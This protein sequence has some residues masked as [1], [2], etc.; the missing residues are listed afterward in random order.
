MRVS[1]R[2]V[3]PA[4]SPLR[5]GLKLRSTYPSHVAHDIFLA[6]LAGGFALVGSVAGVL[7]SGKMSRA[8]ERDRRKAEDARR[9]Q[10]DRRTIY[11]SIWA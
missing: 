7:L 1:C 3:G 2:R 4:R 8:A 6:L 5:L 10:G 9:W 11:Q